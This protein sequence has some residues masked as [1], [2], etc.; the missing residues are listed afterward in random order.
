M[1]DVHVILFISGLRLRSKLQQFEWRTKGDEFCY[2]KLLENYL[3][4]GHTDKSLSGKSRDDQHSAQVKMKLS[5]VFVVTFIIGEW[6][7]DK[8]ATKT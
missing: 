3:I 4:L 6:M 2:S 8:S 5:G 1:K 7:E